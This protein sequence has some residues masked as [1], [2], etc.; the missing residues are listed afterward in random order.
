MRLLSISRENGCLIIHTDE[1][2]RK[3]MLSWRGIAAIEEKCKQFIGKNIRHTTYGN[4]DP[5]VWFSD[6]FLEESKN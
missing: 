5:N 1:G 4:Y 2:D 3:V 6:I